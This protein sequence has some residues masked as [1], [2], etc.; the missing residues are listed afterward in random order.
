MSTK[1]KEPTAEILGYK[2]EKRIGSGGFGEVWSAEAPGGLK[3]ALK[4]VYGFHD[5]RRAQAELKALDRVKSLRHPFLLSLERIEVFEGQLI[6]VTELADSSL[7]D[8]FNEYIAKG[9]PGIP[10]DEMLSY[11]SNAAEALDFL[12][13]E[14]SLQHLDVKPENLLL[15]GSHVKV[16]DFGL[17][18]D[19]QAAS[20][21]LMQGMTPAYAAPE[22]FD[23]TPAPS[24]DQYSLAIM[25]CEMISGVRPFPG[26]T[27]AQLAAQ[28]VHGKPNLRPLPR[29]DHAAVARALSKDP[30]VRYPTCVA[31]VEDLK[32]QRRTN[33]IARKRSEQT[34]A[35]DAGGDTLI[36][37][38]NQKSRVEMTEMVSDGALPFQ[39]NS[40]VSAAPPLC[41]GS[42]S[43]I[44]PTIVITIGNTANRVGQ[45]FKK[46]LL[47]RTGVNEQTPS[48]LSLIHFSEPTRPY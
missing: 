9:E 37:D 5:E 27:P 34:A 32:K 42:E 22:L 23:G 24:S 41:D 8:K 11:M 17:M 13:V 29:G 1:S 21:S 35:T 25:Y 33:R 48:I 10:R 30:G 44:R 43:K 36:F 31:F 4:I 46:K 39:P 38:A 47:K 18:K 7:A 28:H 26:T 3:K 14:K 19:L 20:Q 40:M 2:L 6:V 15:V 16:A 12:S 45:K